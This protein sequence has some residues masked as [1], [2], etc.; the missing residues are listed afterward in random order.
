[1][2]LR[3]WQGIN[4]TLAVLDDTG[5]LQDI[6]VGPEPTHRCVGLLAGQKFRFAVKVANF[7]GQ[8][9]YSLPSDEVEVTQV[10]QNG[11]NG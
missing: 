11:G 1:M 7:Y 4:Y 8:S 9:D 6:Y 5:R 10:K 2:F 3:P